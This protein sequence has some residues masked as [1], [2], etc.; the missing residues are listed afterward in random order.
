MRF[1][2]DV[3]WTASDFVFAA[4][5]IGGVGAAGE[6][7]ARRTRNAA[8]RAGVG[9]ALAA[10]F[11]LVWVNA[12]VGILG[13]ANNPLNLL[14]GAVLAVALFG[15]IAA[16]FRPRGMARAMTSAAVA[17]ALVGLVGV[18]AAGDEPP[19][20]LGIVAVTGFFVALFAGSAWLFRKADRD[21]GP[22]A[23]S[24]PA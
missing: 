4:A 17:Q 8:F 20:A 5:L 6:I 16:E 2:D 15:A 21:R 24:A 19:G 7:T 1:A 23:D 13:N 12:A 10:A 14:Y 3:R 22:P 18:Y 11:L 9:V